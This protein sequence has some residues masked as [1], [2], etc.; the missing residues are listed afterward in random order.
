M[1]SWSKEQIC[2]YMKDRYAAQ[3]QLFISHLGGSCNQCGSV[4]HLEIDHVDPKNKSFSIGRLWAEKRLGQAFVELKKCQLLC[5]D[6]HMTKTAIEAS[7]RQSGKFK[8]GTI[9]GFMK[10]H[11][12][13]TECVKKKRLWHDARNRKR[14]N[15]R[16]G[17]RARNV[18]GVWIEPTESRS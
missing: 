18:P 13:C 8:H 17:Y 6:C 5:H 4:K 11:C 2:Q 16:P 3:R 12:E 9:Y 14:R 10:A 15:G 7:V 1:K